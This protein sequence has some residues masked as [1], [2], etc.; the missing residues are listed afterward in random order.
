MLSDNVFESTDQCTL[1]RKKQ[2]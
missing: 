2:R 1:W